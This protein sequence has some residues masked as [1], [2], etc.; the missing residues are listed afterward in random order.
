MAPGD[1]RLNAQQ[2]YNLVSNLTHEFGPALGGLLPSIGT[3][4]QSHEEIAFL[5]SVLGFLL[6]LAGVLVIWRPLS[7][8]E[9]TALR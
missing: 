6:L 5:F 4:R 2:L 1:A 8:I 7:R 9:A 3:S